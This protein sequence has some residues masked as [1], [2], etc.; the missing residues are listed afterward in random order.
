MSRNCIKRF[1]ETVKEDYYYIIDINPSFDYLQINILTAPDK[2]II[3]VQAETY[4]VKV[5]LV[6]YILLIWL[7]VI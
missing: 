3:T 2:V 7:N 6:D 5:G 1:I 4:V